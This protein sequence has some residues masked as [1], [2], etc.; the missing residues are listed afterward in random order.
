[1]LQPPDTRTTESRRYFPYFDWLRF[2]LACTVMLSHFG[3]ANAWENSGNFAVHVFFMLSGWLIGGILL[4][5]KPADLP[6]FYFNRSVRIWAPYYLAF[7]FLVAAS[8]IREPITAKWLEF[9]AYKATFVWNLFGTDQL[10]AFRDAMPLRGTGNHFWSVNAEEQ[11]YLLAPILLVLAPSKVGRSI[12]TWAAVALLACVTR[13]YGAIV[14]GVCAAIIQRRSP[15][16]HLRPRV[17]LGLMAF[18]AVCIVLISLKVGYDYVAPLCAVPIVLLLAV[19][20][21]ATKMGRLFGGLSYQLYLN[22][23]IGGFVA[24][25]LVIPFGLRHTPFQDALSVALAIGLSACLYIWMDRPLLS[26]RNA[27]FTPARGRLSMAIGYGLVLIGVCFGLII[28][29]R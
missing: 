22:H 19:P 5:L 1:M 18:L 6:H 25:L 15:D 12:I 17:R 20:G 9:I 28:K 14:F 24:T 3:M 29:L 4:E 26:H 7:A 27:L 2:V 10:A 11:F 23:W 21:R 8:L 13:Q 16:F